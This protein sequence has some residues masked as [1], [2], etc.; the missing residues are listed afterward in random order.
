[1]SF[2]I[3]D[4]VPV[5]YQ[6]LFKIISPIEKSAILKV[7]RNEIDSENIYEQFYFGLQNYLVKYQN[8]D[9]S[10][11]VFIMFGQVVQDLEKEEKIEQLIELFPKS[12]ELK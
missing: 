11:L 6:D 2:D 5:E 10:S 7:I 8:E 1:M 12:P 3:T 9:I 4:I